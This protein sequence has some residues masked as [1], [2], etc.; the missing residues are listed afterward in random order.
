M[1]HAYKSIK[2]GECDAALV[3]GSNALLMPQLSLQLNAMGVLSQEGR[4]KTFDESSTKIT[5]FELPTHINYTRFKNCEFRSQETDI[6][7]PK[8]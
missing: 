3:G 8:Q 1:E 4:C 5:V 6:V 7:D 2:N